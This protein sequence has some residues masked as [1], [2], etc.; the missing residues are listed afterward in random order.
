MCNLHVSGKVAACFGVES[1]L[2]AV[3]NQLRMILDV[4]FDP[5][6]WTNVERSIATSLSQRT[7]PRLPLFR[8]RLPLHR[9]AWQ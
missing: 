1:E 3:L 6:D 7:L 5:T 4:H 2:M 9:K 8:H